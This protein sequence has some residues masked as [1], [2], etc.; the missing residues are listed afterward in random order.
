MFGQEDSQGGGESAAES[1]V[2]SSSSEKKNAVPESLESN[3]V[4]TVV[5]AGIPFETARTIQVSTIVKI[6]QAGGTVANLKSSAS[7]IATGD[8]SVDNI[9]S[10]IDAK[11][12]TSSDGGAGFLDVAKKVESGAITVTE[13]ADVKT[14]LDNGID[15]DAQIDFGIADTKTAFQAGYTADEILAVSKLDEAAKATRQATIK[16][17]SAQVVAGQASGETVDKNTLEKIV[18]SSG[19]GTITDEQIAAAKFASTVKALT[20]SSPLLSAIDSV[21][22]DADY[23][24]ETLQTALTSAVTVANTILTDEVHAGTK[25]LT[26]SDVYNVDKLTDNYNTELIKLL[27]KYGAIGDKGSE[28]AAGALNGFSGTST[29]SSSLSDLLKSSSSDYLGLLSTL[30]GDAGIGDADGDDNDFLNPTKNTVLDVSMDKVSLA[31]AAN[32]TVGSKDSSTTID[33][34]NFLPRLQIMPTVRFLLSVQQRT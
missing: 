21:I 23:S 1:S 34:S 32:I 7:V 9:V 5:K 29:T 17:V 31:P 30:T 12:G 15:L 2:S 27:V 10:A 11:I 14:N 4:V 16:S 25:S 24:G 28:L 19:G 3:P 26:P 18:E 20:T 22:A 33:V 8:A 6:A 13:L